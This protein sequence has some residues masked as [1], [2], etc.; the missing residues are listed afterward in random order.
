VLGRGWNELRAGSRRREKASLILA[1][2]CALTAAVAGGQE[3]S[4]AQSAVASVTT[5]L[6]P[7]ADAYVDASFPNKNYGPNQ[8]LRVRSSP[9]QVSYLRFNL[10]SLTGTV[11]SAT[12]RVYANSSQTTGYDV[13]AVSDT[14]WTER[15]I[16][17][18]NAPTYAASVTG[19]SGKVTGGTW[20]AVDVT[21]LALPGHK[22]SLALTTTNSTS[23]SMSSDEGANP[24]QLVVVT[25][26]SSDTQAPTTPTG[27]AA[28]PVSP[29]EID[30]SWSASTDDVGVTGYD[31]YRDGS[32]TPLAT[33]SGSTLTYADKTVS[34][35]STHS[36]TVDAF[37]AAGNHST[38][39]APV[40]AMSPDAPG[41]KTSTSGSAYSVTVC[42]TSPAVGAT[43]TG[44]TSVSATVSTTS[45]NGSPPPTVKWVVFTLNGAP[46]PY[47]LSDYQAPYGFTLPS[48]RW[49]DGT[50]T[51][52]AQVTINDGFVGQ[53]AG[54][55][56][57]F[58]NG[59]T[60][61][62]VNGN[63]FTP[64]SGTRPNGQ[65]PLVVAAVGD[66]AGG[67]TSETQVANEIAGWNPNLVL[68]LGDVY[69]KGSPTEFFNYYD[70]GGTLFSQ[71]RSITDPTI[72][73]HE[74]SYDGQ[75]SGYF[76][77]WD[78]APH[79]YSFDA[80]GWHFIS[81]DS[82]SQF[83]Q[84]VPGTGQYQWLQADLAADT[85]P[86][87]L[88]YYHHPLYN[89]GPEGSATRMSSIWSLLVSHG[90]VLVLNGHDHDYQRWTP[91]DWNGQPNT[92]GVTEIVAGMGGHGL[93]QAVTTDSRL[94]FSDFSHFGALKLQ[95]GAAS[96]SF[97]YI[98]T[99]GVT[100]D[101]GTI[102]CNQPPSD[103]T[104]P[105]APANLTATASSA[106]KVAL[107]WSAS[108]DNIAVT[109]YDVYRDGSLLATLG[110][111]TTYT[112]TTVTTSTTYGYSVDAFDVA[113]NHS[114]LSNTATVTTPAS[115]PPALFVD[116]F[117]SGDFSQWTSNTGLV[118]QTQELRTGTYA[119]RETSTSSSTWAYK[120]LSST[121]T[122][123]YYRLWFKVLSQGSNNAYLLKLRT[124]T[125]TSI[126]GLY[127][128]SSGV[129]ALRNDAGNTTVTS[130]IAASGGT[131]HSIEL[132]ATINTSN[133]AAGA[134]EVW[135]DGNKIAALSITQNLGTAP[136]GRIQLGDN[137]GN[138]TYDIALDDV[139]VDTAFIGS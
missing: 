101:S 110:N 29:T 86:C 61:P 96:A 113:G 34:G 54:I 124:A 81:L 64:T 118:V 130:S 17:Y 51:L 73:N 30:L 105:T 4:R 95:L 60:Q 132:H 134:T 49:V 35:G 92:N 69:E 111:Q 100:R 131:W 76:D 123:L 57:V 121:Q 16:T 32:S 79:Y 119:A 15:G 102:P 10:G 58:S 139:A 74:Y 136:I 68:Y 91:L 137:S 41:C 9:A 89:V 45:L 62:P 56:L 114:D 129:I 84:T 67:E 43:V 120:T 18:G 97:S 138:R 77:Y 70:K 55:S 135:L 3:V 90:G 122:D 103:T 22:L 133:G 94:V 128:S 66:G 23:L 53:Q 78:N 50:Y 87:T 59:I 104:P 116:G 127:R 44:A 2:A 37:D 83:G 108:T 1:V 42:L 85:A 8:A 19:S 112:D 71:F 117:E 27:L 14:S 109:G 13:R 107:S 126:L 21:S 48:A 40:S 12:L 6:M 93:Q 33:V 39:S 11:A 25:S 36:Y 72:G 26:A 82:T 28:N 20:T 24:P 52:Q 98:S 47:V 7:E 63:T 106:G 31:V 75:A 38:Q 5:T 99:D 88:V 125:G 46:N 115:T 65:Q 80:G